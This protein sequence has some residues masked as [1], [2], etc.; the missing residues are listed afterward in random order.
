ML[1]STSHTLNRGPTV[2]LIPWLLHRH[3]WKLSDFDRFNLT[4]WPMRRSKIVA[5]CDPRIRPQQ[6]LEAVWFGMACCLLPESSPWSAALASTQ[7]NQTEKNYEAAVRCQQTQLA[8]PSS[9]TERN[10]NFSLSRLFFGASLE[11][12]C[13][14]LAKG[15]SG[16]AKSMEREERTLS[17]GHETVPYVTFAMADTFLLPNQTRDEWGELVEHSLNRHRA[18]LWFVF[19]RWFKVELKGSDHAFLPVRSSQT[20]ACYSKWLCIRIKSEK[21]KKR[22]RLVI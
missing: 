8:S 10:L 19:V 14:C 22:H 17:T 11:R 7:C 13:S 5:K 16:A 20:A 21:K 9:A 2:L 1:T 15:N 12:R 18:M 4:W 3:R 6:H